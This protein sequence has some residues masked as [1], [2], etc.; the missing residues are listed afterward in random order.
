MLRIPAI[1]SSVYTSILVLAM[2]STAPCRAVDARGTPP[3]LIFSGLVCGPC[4]L[5]LEP[6]GE[7]YDE[8]G[9]GGISVLST[10]VLFFFGLGA[11]GSD[12][13]TL[14]LMIRFR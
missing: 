2:A 11:S 6:D 5:D 3:Q 8:E 10:L 13:E 12:L 7:T 14:S 4:E 1:C 9:G